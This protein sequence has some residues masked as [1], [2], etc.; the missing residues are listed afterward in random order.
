M[1]EFTSQ[2]EPVNLGLVEPRGYRPPAPAAALVASESFVWED[3]DIV[4]DVIHDWSCPEVNYPLTIDNVERFKRWLLKLELYPAKR[5][6][7]P[8][9]KDERLVSRTEKKSLPRRQTGD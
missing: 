4:G 7:A 6:P 1:R 3:E 8:P 9:F 2:P 5:L